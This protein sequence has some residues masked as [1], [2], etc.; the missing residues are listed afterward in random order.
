LAGGGSRAL[1]TYRYRDLGELQ[2]VYHAEVKGL[3]EADSLLFLE[4]EL[5]A[6]GFPSIAHWLAE[7]G[8]TYQQ[9]QE[10]I[11]FTRGW[12]LALQLVIGLR[13]S[14]PLS[15]VY[16]LLQSVTVDVRVEALYEFLFRQELHLLSVQ[17]RDLLTRAFACQ[18]GYYVSELVTL[19]AQPPGDILPLL[20][21][22][23]QVSLLYAIRQDRPGLGPEDYFYVHPMLHHLLRKIAG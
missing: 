6:R 12:P 22:L 11:A 14:L 9:L 4:H 17:T 20:G 23:A 19:E 13:I 18:S 5:A 7:K 3:S 2:G 16:E 21:E 1:L 10:T 8:D 15:S